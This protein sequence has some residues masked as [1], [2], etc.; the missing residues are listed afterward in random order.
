MNEMQF[1]KVRQGDIFEYHYTPK[2]NRLISTDEYFSNNDKLWTDWCAKDGA[3]ESFEKYNITNHPASENI[4]IYMLIVSYLANDKAINSV[5]IWETDLIANSLNQ[6]PTLIDW[7][8]QL[9][10]NYLV[11]DKYVINDVGFENARSP[12]CLV[13]QYDFQVPNDNTGLFKLNNFHDLVE[14]IKPGFGDTDNL[15][16]HYI[17]NDIDKLISKLQGPTKPEFGDLLMDSDIFISLLIGQDL[18]YYDYLVIKSKTDLSATLDILTEKITS[19]ASEYID[20]IKLVLNSGEMI[21]L[22]ESLLRKYAL[23]QNV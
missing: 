16:N 7:E 13:A 1:N 21:K 14:L 15:S 4:L 9:E 6:I 20:G 23:Q 11:R 8:Y 3:P 19:F 5:G 22:I 12:A 2:D 18:G 17:T 10:H